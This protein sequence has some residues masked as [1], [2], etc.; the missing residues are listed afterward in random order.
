MVSGGCI[1]AGARVN[2]SLLFSDVRVEVGSELNRAV[3]L[4]HVRIGRDCRIT[5]AVIDEH[6]EI[7]DGTLIGQD[8]DADR[9]K[10]AV[11]DQGVVLVCPHML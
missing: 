11:T 3:V 10:Y 4:P 6:C 8:L 1:V 9:K 2:Q 5:R 7:P